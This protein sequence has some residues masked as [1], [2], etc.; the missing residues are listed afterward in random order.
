MYVC[1][2]S[3]FIWLI[4]YKSIYLDYSRVKGPQ[5]GSRLIVLTA[6]E[7]YKQTKSFSKVVKI[8]WLISVRAKL[9]QY[10]TLLKIP[11]LK[12]YSMQ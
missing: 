10:W 8:L 6:V 9:G 4:S 5:P 7:T 2:S 1:V 11:S 3:S 12:I